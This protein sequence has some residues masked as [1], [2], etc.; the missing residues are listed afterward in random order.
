MTEQQA[1]GRL[2]VRLKSSIKKIDVNSLDLAFDG[3]VQTIPND[4]VIV[5][6]GGILPTEFL[7]SIGINM[8][9]KYGTA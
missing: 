3:Q 9:T 2:N 7:K 1:S 8:D 6:A 4:A 5:C